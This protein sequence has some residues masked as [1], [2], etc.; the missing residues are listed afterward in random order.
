MSLAVEG[1][2][3]ILFDITEAS[4]DRQE[5]ARELE[6]ELTGVEGQEA[7]AGELR[8]SLEHLAYVSV[9]ADSDER[10]ALSLR[11]SPADLPVEI[12]AGLNLP[13]ATREEWVRDL[14]DE[15][16]D[17]VV[18][19]PS[20]SMRWRSFIGWAETVNPE[21]WERVSDLTDPMFQHFE[22]AVRE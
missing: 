10:A 11:L 16:G 21:L 3:A 15:H 4:A 5:L 14:F 12:P 13:V 8:G 1:G 2:S 22:W 9:L 7:L 17:L 20:D 19:Q 18:P 6:L